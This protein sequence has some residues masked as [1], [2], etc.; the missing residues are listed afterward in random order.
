M[1]SVSSAAQIAREKRVDSNLEEYHELTMHMPSL[2][3]LALTGLLASSPVVGIATQG[4]AAVALRY[5]VSYFSRNHFLPKTVDLH[6]CRV[7]LQ[8]LL[9]LL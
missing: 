3:Q 2:A 4:G 8:C 9:S 7:P 6:R 1:C 5:I